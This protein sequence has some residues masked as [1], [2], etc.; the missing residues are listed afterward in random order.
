MKVH[1]LQ[2][3]FMVSA[4]VV[5]LITIASTE[6]GKSLLPNIF[7]REGFQVIQLSQPLMKCP[8]GSVPFTNS[9]GDM[10][11][12]STTLIDGSC[13]S[14]LCTLSP[15]H[16]NIASCKNI[17]QDRFEKRSSSFCPKSKPFYFENSDTSGCSSTKPSINGTLHD[18]VP[19]E[20]KCEIFENEQENYIKKES[21]ILQKLHEDFVCP[22][23]PE[24]TSLAILQSE[25]KPGIIWCTSVT[26]QGIKQCGEDK[27]LLNYLDVAYPSWRNTFSLEQK[28]LFCS[29]HDRARKENKD[30]TSFDFP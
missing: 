13:P 21:C 22:F 8:S 25:G 24:T 15:V 4:I 19:V 6:S 16:D 7:R 11:C 29:L 17:L 18:S 30:I 10:D 9:K 5:L 26:A 28:N 2:I 20:Q 27:T 12:C 23:P 1:M 14:I 3:V